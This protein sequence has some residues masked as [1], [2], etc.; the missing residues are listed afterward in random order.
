MKIVLISV[1]FSEAMGYSENCLPKALASLGTEVHLITTNLQPYFNSPNYREVYE[2][3]LGPAIVDCGVKS[4]DGFTLHRLP[5]IASGGRPRIRG[6]SAA[7][8]SLRPDIVQTFEA[9][10][11]TTYETAWVK[12]RLGYKLFLEAHEHASVYP[13]S[14]WRAHVDGL[15]QQTVIAPTAGQWL[16]RATEKCYP[17]S[18]D[19]AEIAIR[20]FGIQRQKTFVTSLGVDTDLFK[21]VSDDGIRERREQTRRRWG[22]EPSEI[23]CIYTGRFSSSKDPLCL[24][25]AI[26]A[27]T[28]RGHPFRGLFF[29]SGTAEEVA[30][31]QRCRGCAIHPFVP[32]SQLPIYYQGA[33]I[34]VWPKQESTSQLDAAAC[35]LPIIISDRV[36][37]TER[38]EG[39]GLV[40]HEGDRADLQ[41]A[42][43]DLSDTK[44]RQQLGMAGATKMR[45]KFSWRLIA[46]QRLADYETA[47]HNR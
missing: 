26:D 36:A 27:L 4:I 15:W 17:I 28:T 33:D 32:F 22:F 20:Y 42:L 16:S 8:R 11:W 9:G 25:Q 45:Q 37:A 47:L 30:A 6:L 2:P 7:L 3:F 46:E 24:A 12:R 14:S 34:A 18:P 38:V 29:G 13:G 43:L 1:W 19:A 35:G 10:G 21:P 39:N 41:C 23:V 31:I 5:H 40:Y 44:R